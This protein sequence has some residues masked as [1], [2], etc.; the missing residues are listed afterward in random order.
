MIPLRFHHGLAVPAAVVLV[1]LQLSSGLGCGPF[2]RETVLQNPGYVLRS[3]EFHFMD[4][5]RR[6]AG[7]FV[8]EKE[9]EERACSLDREMEEMKQI[10]VPQIGDAAARHAWLED[11]RLLRRGMLIIADRSAWRVTK[12]KAKASAPLDPRVGL[13]QWPAPLPEEIRIYLDGASHYLDHL[14]SKQPAD[15]ERARARWKNLLELPADQRRHRGTW[16]AWMLFRTSPAK[17]VAEERHWLGLV[18]KLRAEGAEDCQHFDEEATVIL[19][20]M[21]PPPAGAPPHQHISASEHL[22]ALARRQALGH[23]HGERDLADW[24]VSDFSYSEEEAKAISSDPDLVGMVSLA[25]VEQTQSYRTQSSPEAIQTRLSRWI[26]LLHPRV[27]KRSSEF[28]L[29]AWAAY[30]IGDFTG[31]DRCLRL[32]PETDPAAVWLR[33]KIAA[34]EGRLDESRRLLEA[35]SMEVATEAPSPPRFEPADPLLNR[36]DQRRPTPG[37]RGR[38]RADQ[39]KGD[40]AVVQIAQSRYLD[41]LKTLLESEHWYDAAFVAERL[42]SPEEVLTLARRVAP[43]LPDVAGPPEGLTVEEIQDRFVSQTWD[44]EPGTIADRFRHLVARKTARQGWFKDAR[45]FFPPPMRDALDHYVEARHRGLDRRTPQ[46]ERAAA[47]WKA[48]RMHRSLGMAFF[49]YEIGPDHGIY[50]GAFDLGDLA[51]G[52]LLGVFDEAWDGADEIT[53]AVRDRLR[54]LTAVTPDE[55]WSNRQYGPGVKPRFHYRHDAS[56]L[57]WEAAALLPENDEL[58][59]RILCIAG[60][61]LKARDAAAADRFYQALVARH[62]ETALGREA[63]SLRWFPGIDTNYNDRFPPLSSLGRSERNAAAH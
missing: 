57:A 13:R 62:P 21:G 29:L 40:L 58:A 10:M 34:M 9:R 22:R 24:A 4:Q 48:A 30:S 25:F 51:E 2:F 7:A 61:W 47:L 33:G 54:A 53:P 17:E 43:A 38:S 35:A 28:A 27:T 11:Y 41:A 42:L 49:G 45:P 23:T 1:I 36:F 14:A 46:A 50:G 18:R 12:E 3:P 52:R 26:E 60:T 16:A 32:A 37:E 8:A 19:H 39:A 20:R 55:R 44:E 59:A 63:E 56:Q 15:L 31:A 6:R 5:F